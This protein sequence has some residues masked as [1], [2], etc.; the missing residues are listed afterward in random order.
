MDLGYN[1]GWKPLLE[2][3]VVVAFAHT[4]GGGDL[5]RTWYAWG[6]N[7]HKL[8]AIEDY[9]ACAFYLRKRFGNKNESIL[10]LK[11]EQG[12]LSLVAKAFSAGGVL[13]GASINRNPGLFDKVVLTN[14]FVDVFSTMGKE[15]LFLTEHEYDEFGNPNADPIVEARIRSY[16]PIYNLDPGVQAQQTTTRFLL[17]G[18]LDDPN[19]PYWN[20][21]LYFRKLLDGYKGGNKFN[22]DATSDAAKGGQPKNDCVFLELQTEGGHH[23]SGKNRIDVLALENAFILND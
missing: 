5:G 22:G 14:A 8:K 20:A 2:R 13:V 3:G 16:C 12:Q 17:I 7:E 23:F 11:E 9:E 21:S 10:P 19:V 18:T 15:S 1:P 4:R 6:R